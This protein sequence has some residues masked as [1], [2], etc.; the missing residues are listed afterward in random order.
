MDLILNTKTK[1]NQYKL[2]ILSLEPDINVRAKYVAKWIKKFTNNCTIYLLGYAS[3]FTNTIVEIRG[4]PSVDEL[5]KYLRTVCCSQGTS[6]SYPACLLKGSVAVFNNENRL[7]APEL[8]RYA[9]Y[10][11]WMATWESTKISG[12]SIE[13]VQTYTNI[14]E[15]LGKVSEVIIVNGIYPLVKGEYVLEKKFVIPTPMCPIRILTFQDQLC[16]PNIYKNAIKNFG[17]TDINRKIFPIICKHFVGDHKYIGSIRDLI[18]IIEK[19]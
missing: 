5:G 12:I 10:R 16:L 18:T 4:D 9:G 6:S 19:Y 3:Y 14:Q 1:T 13:H 17:N 15:I 7:F 8:R 11:P 2:I